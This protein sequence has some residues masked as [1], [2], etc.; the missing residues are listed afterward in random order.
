MTG[1]LLPPDAAIDLLLALVES[2]DIGADV[3][4]GDGPLGVSQ[5]ADG[6]G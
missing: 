1:L 2:R 6:A 4:R 5:G 3:R